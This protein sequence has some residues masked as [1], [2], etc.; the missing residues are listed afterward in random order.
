MKQL[1]NK[2]IDMKDTTTIT[3]IMFLILA[4][5]LLVSWKTFSYKE[6]KKV[7]HGTFYCVMMVGS[8]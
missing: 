2:Q 1:R 3:V 6:C 7:G 5:G 8:K 4:I